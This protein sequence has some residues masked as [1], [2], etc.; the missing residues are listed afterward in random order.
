MH[1]SHTILQPSSDKVHRANTRPA[2]AIKATAP[3]WGLKCCAGQSTGKMQSMESMESVALPLVPLGSS[4]GGCA[5]SQRALQRSTLNARARLN[6]QRSTKAQRSMLGRKQLSHIGISVAAPLAAPP[7]RGKGMVALEHSWGFPARI[8]HVPA[9]ANQFRP[10]P[11][12]SSRSQH[13][14]ANSSD[15]KHIQTNSK[16]FLHMLANFSKFNRIQANSNNSK[17][18]PSGA[19]TFK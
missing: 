7:E 6:A 19:N 10:N 17:Q 4:P 12:T 16:M 18:L 3:H 14:P 13:I 2:N 5:D 1:A 11:A 8:K 15:L 9:I